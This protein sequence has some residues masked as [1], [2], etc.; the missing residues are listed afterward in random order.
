MDYIPIITKRNEPGSDFVITVIKRRKGKKFGIWVNIVLLI[1]TLASTI[2]VGEGLYVG[3]FNISS[4]GPIEYF[5]GFLYFSLPLMIIL[6]SHELGHYFVARRNGVAASLPFFIPAPTILGTL[7]AFISLRDPLP[8]RKTLIKVGAA[9]PIVGFIMSIIVGI[10]GAYLGNVQHPVIVTS[11][12]ISYE[13]S[14][15]F[16]YSIVPFLFT[17]NVHPVAFAAW[18]GFLVTA[19]NLFPV[20]QLDGGHIA[21]GLL[22]ERAKYFSYAFLMV[23]II[24]GVYYL[25]WI[26]FAVIIIILGLNH[27]P[28]LNDISKPGKKELVVGAVAIMLIILCFSPVPIVEHIIPESVNVSLSQGNNFIVMNDSYFGQ[29]NYSLN[30]QN[31]NNVSISVTVSPEKIPGFNVTRSINISLTAHQEKVFYINY[32]PENYSALGEHTI[33]INVSTT[34]KSFEFVR[35]AIVVSL[36]QNI[37]PNMIFSNTNDTWI[38]FINYGKSDYFGIYKMNNSSQFI[39]S[40]TT[41]NATSN[42]TVSSVD[43]ATSSTKTIEIRFNNPDSGVVLVDNRYQ[44]MVVIYN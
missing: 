5:Y 14:L 42:T 2:Y 15:P 1:A 29:E 44:A 38:T 12:Q 30:V 16:I 36:D 4:N 11:T 25:S 7:G 19:I 23:L 9:G 24:L 35:D 40:N 18:V 13:I 31:V 43:I 27:P 20:G 37:T 6:G 33:Y 3:Y 22:G 21:R 17:T 34:P 26:I 10:V 39:I 41:M 28:P 32:I 8:D